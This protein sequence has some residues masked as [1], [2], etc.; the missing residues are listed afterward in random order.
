MSE[1]DEG[2]SVF[3]YSYSHATYIDHGGVHFAQFPVRSPR[4]GGTL[5][6]PHLP[7]GLSVLCARTYYS[8]AS[9]RNGSNPVNS[10]GLQQYY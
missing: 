2:L 9:D 1:G 5:Q 6:A 7:E 10:K 4:S 3:V 8:V